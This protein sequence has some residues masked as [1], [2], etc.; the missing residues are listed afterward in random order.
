MF[1]GGVCSR[2]VGCGRRADW[3]CFFSPSLRLFTAPIRRTYSP[4]ALLAQVHDKEIIGL[5][6]HPHLN[7]V[8]TYAMDGEVR[9]WKP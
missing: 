4:L 3:F 6:V 1:L 7:L 2:S 9:I 5:T 8:A